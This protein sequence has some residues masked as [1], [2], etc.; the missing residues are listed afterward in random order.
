MVSTGY[1]SFRVVSVHPVDTWKLYVFTTG[2]CWFIVSCDSIT[3]HQDLE[4]PGVV[5]VVLSNLAS[6]IHSQQCAPFPSILWLVI[7]QKPVFGLTGHLLATLRLV[8]DCLQVLW[9][10]IEKL[11]KIMPVSF[12]YVSP[13]IRI[14]EFHLDNVSTCL[15]D[16]SFLIFKT[17]LWTICESL[18]EY[19]KMITWKKAK[20]FSL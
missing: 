12:I 4:A 19:H 1:I 2:T 17:I 3:V 9:I 6:G 18:L 16:M 20:S 5:S 15:L 14:M 13:R 7:L 11:L 10:T 8:D